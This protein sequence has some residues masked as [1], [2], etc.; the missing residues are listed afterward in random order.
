MK[1]KVA[2]LLSGGIDS[3]F[4]CYLLVSRGFSVVGITFKNGYKFSCN[5]S[6]A[7]YVCGKLGVPYHVIDI[8]KEFKKFVIDYFIKS[9]LQGLTP[10]PCVVCN[11]YI[12]FGI[13]L[14]YVKKLGCEYI[15]TGHYAKTLEEDGR[16]ILTRGKSIFKSQEYFLAGVSPQVLKKAIFPLG[17]YTKEEVKKKIKKLDIY[18]FSIVESKDICFIEDDYR[19][20]IRSSLKNHNAYAGKIKD[21]KG[22]LLGTH[23]GIYYFTYGQ[24]E[25]LGISN[26]RPLY[27]KDINYKTKEII[28]AEREL[29]LKKKFKVKELNWFYPPQ[30]YKNLKVKLRYN[31][32]PLACDIKIENEDTLICELKNKDIPSP[33]QF[34]VFYDQDR[35]VVAGFIAKEN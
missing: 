24:R 23:K 27:V 21:I 28:V 30:N 6:S 19:E 18:P 11:R 8:K 29:I 33:G 35:V 26:V 25:G 10:N 20:F 2:V 3:S 1:K 5:I 16:L 13:L 32:Y 12:K 31:S 9:Y 7:Y 15:A 34:A 4:A 14:D 22:N 17:D